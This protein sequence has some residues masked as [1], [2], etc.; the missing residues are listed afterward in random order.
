MLK[1]VNM[2]TDLSKTLTRNYPARLGQLHL[3]DLP[4]M[5]SS[6]LNTIKKCLHKVT[7]QKIH[8][9]RSGDP[10]LPPWPALS[11]HGSGAQPPR[12]LPRHPDSPALFPHARRPAAT[13]Q[14]GEAGK[15]HPGNPEPKPATGH[16]LSPLSGTPGDKVDGRQQREVDLSR[17]SDR[18]LL[19]MVM[20]VVALGLAIFQG[21]RGLGAPGLAGG[22]PAFQPR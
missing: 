5:L 10:A 15:R 8:V 4:P 13:G 22:M 14:G 1:Q 9:C 21:I 6:A 12:P 16:A 20:A 3:V 18:A 11:A 2:I 17:I 19:E 7:Q